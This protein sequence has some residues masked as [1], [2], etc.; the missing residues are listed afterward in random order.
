MSTIGPSA[1]TRDRMLR[2]SASGTVRAAQR[3][4]VRVGDQLVGG[5]EEPR[6]ERDD[7]AGSQR[8][9]PPGLA[10]VGHMW[11]AVHDATDAVPAEVGVDLVAVRAGDLRDRVRD[12]TDPLADH[13]RRD[14]G[15]QR[16]L[17]GVDDREIL[18]ARRADDERDRR[19][20]D[21]AVDRHREIERDEVAVLD[22]V[23]EGEAVQHGIV[24]RGADDLAERSG[25]ERRVIVDVA[26]LR[27]GAPD[28]VV[29][30][31]VDRQQVRA[32]L[33][34]VA[35]RG[36]RLC[37]EPPC[38]AHGLDLGGS[39]QLDHPVPLRLHH[40]VRCS[41]CMDSPLPVWELARSCR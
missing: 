16:P 7:Q 20:G 31:A 27:P 13:G 30:A 5:L 6:L 15:I 40:S 2:V 22:R 35:Q 3:P 23:V 9:A 38:G 41:G 29:G 11:I 19:I 28:Q 26:G 4:A 33:G 36:Q 10:V 25:A 39:A 24:D 21:P 8:V 37:H 18:V 12:V 1:V 17:G 14:R 32:D 34:L